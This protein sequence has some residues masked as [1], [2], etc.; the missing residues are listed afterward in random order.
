MLKKL[1]IL[2]FFLPITVLMGCGSDFDD[3]SIDY[4][5]LDQLDIVLAE[6]IGNND[7]HLFGRLRDLVV[8]DNG[9]FFVSDWSSVTIQQFNRDGIYEGTIAKEG[10]GP[11]ELSSFFLLY[12]GGKDK[13]I[14]RHRGMRQHIDYFTDEYGAGEYS[15]SES[16]SF[17]APG[18][19]FVTFLGKFSESEFY[20]LAPHNT[21][22]LMEARKNQSGFSYVP[23]AT[24][25]RYEKI[26]QD[27]L[28]V[29]KRPTVVAEYG[30]RSMMVIGMPPY[31]MD[32]RFQVIDEDRYLI[33]R[34]D[35]ASI[36]IFN[37]THTIDSI[38]NLEIKKRPVGDD[39][40][41]EF[42]ENIPQDYHGIMLERIPEFKPPFLNVWATE[43]S[44]FLHMDSSS[45][46][47][48]LMVMTLEGEPV[49]R[50]SLSEFDEI[51]VI[52]ENRIYTLHKNPE[53]AETIRIYEL[54]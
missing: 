7:D 36:T 54:N 26:I 22:D 9:T 12:N 39:E 53:E 18:D 6:E 50:I 25:D 42:L 28:H 49:G 33:A 13:L 37:K 1:Y 19:R 46:G 21:N 31:Q 3:S 24:A 38:L 35:S 52:K 40:V 8:M 14:V 41:S 10:G 29:L 30:E 2:S 51:K 17:E 15:Y 34:P 5:S 43:D 4:R 27:S 16:I 45:E 20:A 47:K 48:E 44:I 23:I 11:G 32:D